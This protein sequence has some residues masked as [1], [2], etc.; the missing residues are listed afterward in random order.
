MNVRRSPP[1][2]SRHFVPGGCKRACFLV[3]RSQELSSLQILWLE[4]AHLSCKLLGFA[5]SFH[6]SCLPAWGKSKN[7]I[8]QSRTWVIWAKYEIQGFRDRLTPEKSFNPSASVFLPKKKQQLS[9]TYF[10]G[11]TLAK[12]SGRW[13]ALYKL[14]AHMLTLINFLCANIFFFLLHCPSSHYIS[15]L[16]WRMRNCWQLKYF[17]QLF[18][19]DSEMQPLN[20]A[21]C[22]ADC[23][24]NSFVLSCVSSFSVTWI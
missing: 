15:S 9:I 5:F 23:F 1:H 19:W 21:L 12:P 7:Q 16:I 11:H 3:T 22:S 14:Y 24:L 2:Y 4:S 18:F 17:L 10:V 20:T 6:A 13:K 8:L